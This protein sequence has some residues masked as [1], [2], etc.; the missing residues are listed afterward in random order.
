MVVRSSDAKGQASPGL[1]DSLTRAFSGPARV[2]SIA[3]RRDRPRSGNRSVRGVLTIA[4]RSHGRPQESPSDASARPVRQPLRARGAA[5]GPRR[6]APR[7]LTETLGS[8]APPRVLGPTTAPRDR[9]RRP[10]PRWGL[11]M[12]LSETTGALVQRVPPSPGARR[13][14]E[15]AAWRERHAGARS[16]CRATSTSRGRF[17]ISAGIELSGSSGIARSAE[18]TRQSVSMKPSVQVCQAR[19]LEAMLAA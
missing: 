4:N 1:C 9:G 12:V 11:S 19:S 15:R 3:L 8:Q 7:R 14:P 16:A 2:S 17:D 10:S 13:A 5:A 18:P 6:R